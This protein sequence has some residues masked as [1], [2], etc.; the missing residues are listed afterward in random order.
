M[1]VVEV[2]RTITTMTAEL[3]FWSHRLGTV[4]ALQTLAR[5]CAESEDGNANAEKHKTRQ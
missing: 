2:A 3:I 1:Y 5:M 4:G